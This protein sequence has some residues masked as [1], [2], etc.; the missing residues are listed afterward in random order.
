MKKLLLAVLCSASLLFASM[1]L[2]SASKKELM[3]IKGIGV[4]K[5]EQIIEFRKNKS[6]Q[7]ADELK[8][9]KGFGKKLIENIKLA[10]AKKKS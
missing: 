8:V 9:I 10:L 4:K 7:S 5:A 6:I 3:S 2:N 1:D